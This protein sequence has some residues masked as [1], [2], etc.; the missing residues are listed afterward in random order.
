MTIEPTVYKTKT[1]RNIILRSVEHEDAKSM[2]EYLK[3]TCAETEFLMREPAEV[4]NDL[5]VEEMFIDNILESQNAFML[6]A[7]IYGEVAGSCAIN[8]VSLT[9]RACHRCVLGVALYKKY[10]GQGIGKAMIERSLEIARQIGYEQCE[11]E[12]FAH[13]ENAIALYKSLGFEII[14][15][16]PDAVKYADGRYV[17]ELRMMRKL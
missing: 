2:L 12:V 14:G 3:T 1:G 15:D 7:D 10:W 8:P 4:I 13:N 11:L 16:T 6:I 5:E 9:R 17:H